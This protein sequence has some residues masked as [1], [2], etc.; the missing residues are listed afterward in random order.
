MYEVL[1][2]GKI[3]SEKRGSKMNRKWIHMIVLVL[4]MSVLTACGQ[5]VEEQATAGMDN[6][7]TIF[8]SKPTAT[9]ESIGHIKL[10]L[11]KGYSIEKGIDESNYTIV[12]G[13]DSYILFVNPYETEDSQLHYLILKEDLKG[14]MIQ[15]KTF[16][17]EGV[18]GFSAVISQP[19]EE[20]QLVVSVGGVK[21]TTISK[22]K[23]I[24]DKL[25]EMMQIVRSIHVI[26]NHE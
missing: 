5:S 9:N 8:N 20:Y 12:H 13:K 10:Y 14:E 17:A 19:E 7:E 3:L 2:Y 21:F 23:K 24:D 1:R 11:P 22:D 25:Q 18:F 16:Q 6:A 4:T 15:E 26:E